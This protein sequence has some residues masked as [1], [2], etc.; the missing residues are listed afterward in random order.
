MIVPIHM[1]DIE[2]KSFIKAANTVRDATYEVKEN[3]DFCKYFPVLT[4][5]GKYV[6]ISRSAPTNLLFKI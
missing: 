4:K 6:G 3:L 2:K 5:T 1:N